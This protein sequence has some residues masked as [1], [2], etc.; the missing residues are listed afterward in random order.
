[1]EALIVLL[2][3]AL[4]LVPVLLI[5]ALVQISGLKSR[6]SGLER[7]LAQLRASA[8][9]P[10][11]PRG[12]E[13]ETLAERIERIDREALPQTPARPIASAAPPAAT[14]PQTPP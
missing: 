1:M 13:D 9:A 8:D 14:A 5:V 3:L 2:V 6:V 4:L 12:R 10:A 11:A 7:T